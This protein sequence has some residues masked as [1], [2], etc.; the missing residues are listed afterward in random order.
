MV[1]PEL[2]AA[3]RPQTMEAEI[4]N[5]LDGLNSRMDIYNAAL[6]K[7]EEGAFSDYVRALDKRVYH[8][9]A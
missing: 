7:T 3:T 5:Y 4:I 1:P 8:A 9:T 6:S 2:G